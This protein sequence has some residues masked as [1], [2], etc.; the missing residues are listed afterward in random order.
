MLL[1]LRL[2]PFTLHSNHNGTGKPVP[3]FFGLRYAQHKEI[4]YA[5]ESG[6]SPNH[7]SDS[8]RYDARSGIGRIA[9]RSL[10]AGLGTR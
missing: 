6:W 3:L 5:K 1:E 4:G 7:T 9:R 10:R 2:K 8:G